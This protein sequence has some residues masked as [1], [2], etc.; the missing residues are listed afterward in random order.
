[1]PQGGIEEVPRQ[2]LPPVLAESAGDATSTG[3]SQGDHGTTTPPARTDRADRG[4]GQSRGTWLGGLLSSR[5]LG[6]QI[7]RRGHL[8]VHAAEAVSGQED[9]RWLATSEARHMGAV[10]EAGGVPTPRDRQVGNGSADSGA[11]K[12]LGKP[13]AGE[14]HARFDERG[15]ETEHGLGTAAPAKIM[16]GQRRTYRPPRQPPTLPPWGQSLLRSC[17]ATR[18]FPPPPPA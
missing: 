2:T 16:R 8:R 13:C 5:Q 14:P 15:L 12:G 18:S 1:M 7:P 11:V 3:S 17:L 9:Q 4:R 6:A 10:R